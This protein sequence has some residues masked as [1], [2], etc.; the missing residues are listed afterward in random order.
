M[1]KI[2]EEINEV[3]QEKGSFSIDELTNTYE[4]PSEFIQQVFIFIF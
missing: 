3:L 1:N 2:S 4:L